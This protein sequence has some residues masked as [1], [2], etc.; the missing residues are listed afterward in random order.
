MSKLSETIARYCLEEGS[1]VDC[2]VFE[3]WIA[4]A[5]EQERTIEEI[6]QQSME[7]RAELETVKQLGRNGI[8]S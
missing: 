8:V 4:A 3:D 7:L 1:I 5:R 2:E 6:V